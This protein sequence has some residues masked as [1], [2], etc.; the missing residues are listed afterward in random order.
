MYIDSVKNRNSPP[1]IL[2]RESYRK[3]GKVKKRT[4][5]NLTSWTK[6]LVDDFRLLLKGASLEADLPVAF[7]ISESLPH[8]HVAAVYGTLKKLGLDR[9][10]NSRRSR[11]RDICVGLIVSRILN[12]SSKLAT[13]TAFAG[14]TATHTLGKILNITDV[15]EH[16][17]YSAMDWLLSRQSNI[18]TALSKK[19]LQDGSLVL[20][21]LTSTY[22]EGRA[23]PLAHRG[24]SRDGKKGTLQ[25]EFGLLCDKD[26]RPVSVEV[27]EGNTADPNTVSIQIEKLQKRF[28]LSRVILVGDRGMITE[29]RIREEFREVKGLDWVSALKGTAIR[30]LIKKGE[31]ET[32]LFDER[33]MMEITSTAYSGERLI[34]C[35]NPL[36]AAERKKKREELLQETEKLLEKVVVATCRKTNPLKGE[37]EIGLRVGKIINKFKMGKHFSINVTDN[38]F[39]YERKTK[40]IMKEAALDGFYVVRTS[41]SKE[42]MNAEDAVSTYKRLAEVERAFRSIKTVDL[43]VRPVFHHLA[44]RVRAHVFL[45]MLAYYVE[46]HMK[47]SLAPLLFKDEDREVAKKER[48]SVVAKAKRSK[49]ALRKAQTKRTEEG[50]KVHSFQG[51]LQN[52]AT[53]SRN[54]I[55]PVAKNMPSL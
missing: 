10:I 2:L 14:N 30:T 32:S 20:Y 5:A 24:Y 48:I 12:P 39:T 41:V 29:A 49:K 45:C 16:E 18:E 42:V 3:D 36:L 53:I 31:I 6:K 40:E 26:G 7:D 44:D 46:W 19:H 21:D 4:L 23:C 33:D 52:L 13:A 35:R 37:A 34:V 28:G 22:F 38:N 27:F 54:S 43:K 55:E 11:F 17:I 47:E 51:I 8:G 25:I 1:C 9:I 15:T 50:V